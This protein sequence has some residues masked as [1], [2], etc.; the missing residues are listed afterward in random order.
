MKKAIAFLLC[1][2]FCLSFAACG[3]QTP[4]A[5]SNSG[6]NQTLE[7]YIEASEEQLEQLSGAFED[8]GLEMSISVRGNSLVYSYKYTIDV[9][10]AE[11]IKTAMETMMETVAPTFE[12]VL[13]GIK[14]EVP[15]TESLIVEYFDK[16]GK[17]IY[18]KEF[19]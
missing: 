15:S 8:S 17:E 19:K 7:N 11:T 18:S 1:M 9:G 4:T 16:D 13:S 10:D 5:N 2:V 12:N 14:K 6:N 3:R